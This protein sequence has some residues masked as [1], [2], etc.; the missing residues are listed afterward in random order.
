[1]SD[2]TPVTQHD[3]DPVDT[4][5]DGEVPVLM[6]GLGVILLQLD[7]TRHDLELLLDVVV[8][9]LAIQRCEDLPS[10]VVLAVEN[11]PP[12]NLSAAHVTGSSQIHSQGDSGMKDIDDQH[13]ANHTPLRVERCEVNG[14]LSSIHNLQSHRIKELADGPPGSGQMVAS[15]KRAPSLTRGCK[16]PAW[17]RGH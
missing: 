15:V 17:Y 7:R 10:F 14:G 11:A 1:M 6:I 2:S 8:L 12:W 13:D 9:D 5:E 16:R 4:L 3:T